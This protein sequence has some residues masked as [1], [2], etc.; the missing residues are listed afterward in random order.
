M[1]SPAILTVVCHAMEAQ[2]LHRPATLTVVC[3]VVEAQQMHRQQACRWTDQIYDP[4]PEVR[5][6][7]HNPVLHLLIHQVQP[8]LDFCLLLLQHLLQLFLIQQRV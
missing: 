3:H 6:A 1:H 4:C 7:L 5:E 8:A 2:Q